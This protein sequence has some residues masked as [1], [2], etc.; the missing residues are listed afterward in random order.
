MN[1]LSQVLFI[2]GNKMTNTL[3]ITSFLKY[4]LGK[5]K[6]FSTK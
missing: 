2:F 4:C 3:E 1:L 6:Q 5:Y